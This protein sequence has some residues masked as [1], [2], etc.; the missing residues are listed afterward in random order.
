MIGLNKNREKLPDRF[1]KKYKSEELKARIADEGMWFLIPAVT[2][3]ISSPDG[4]RRIKENDL[5]FSFIDEYFPVFPF[6]FEP[7]MQDGR[8]VFL[9]DDV[10]HQGMGVCVSKDI[11]GFLEIGHFWYPQE[12]TEKNIPIGRGQVYIPVFSAPPGEELADMIRKVYLRKVLPH[13]K[14]CTFPFQLNVTVTLEGDF[15]DELDLSINTIRDALKNE[16]PLVQRNGE[17]LIHFM[18]AMVR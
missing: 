2:G 16:D 8:F 15:L 1:E 17:G 18:Q 13:Q 10:K 3:S 4:V 12:Y 14:F 9:P 5:L 11:P 7:Y 6:A